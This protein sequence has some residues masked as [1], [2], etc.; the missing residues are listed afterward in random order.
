MQRSASTFHIHFM[1]TYFKITGI[2]LVLVTALTAAGYFFWYKPA[3]DNAPAARHA[4]NLERASFDKPIVHRIRKNASV[5][6]GYARRNNY[7]TRICFLID[8]G[9]S[10]GKTRFFVYNLQKDSIEKSGLVTHGSGSDKGEDG[11]YFSNIP[12]SNCTSLGKYKIGHS[13]NGKFG[14]A[15]KLYGL[16]NSNSRA[17]ER[18]VVLHAHECV[19][20]DEIYPL[21]ICQ[22]WGC[23]T[24]SPSFLQSLKETID[25]EE[26]PILLSIYK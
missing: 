15:Y 19:P 14:L 26:S 2:F 6:A 5:L 24:V 21:T 23:P 3:F 8:M 17:F 22:S 11:L 13:Y 9:I 1:R 16:D 7:S 12:G 18:F 20:N 4:A 10:S 25:R